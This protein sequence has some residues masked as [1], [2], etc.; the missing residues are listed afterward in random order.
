MLA[1]LLLGGCGA[2][3]AAERLAEESLERAIESGAEGSVSA[4]I[5]LDAGE[6][7]VEDDEGNTLQSVAGAELPRDFP[8][9][10]P[11]VDGLVI[12]G[13]STT[14]TT[15]QAGWNVNL[16]IAGASP[17]DV[18]DEAVGLLADAGYV[19]ESSTDVGDTLGEV[20]VGPQWR[21]AVSVIGQPTSTTVSYLVTT[22]A[23]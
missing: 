22:T 9:D 2:D 6:I 18:R 11:L 1:A 20:M 15:G 12:S 7:T 16:D 8:E 4:D 17:R 23:A 3:A 21:I 19:S 10:I 5:D 13:V 14:D